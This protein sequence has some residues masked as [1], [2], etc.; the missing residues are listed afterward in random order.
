[1]LIY[2]F[3]FQVENERTY[4]V[5]LHYKKG[6]LIS[7]NVHYTGVVQSSNTTEEFKLSEVDKVDDINGIIS[8]HFNLIGNQGNHY[9][10]SM[11]WDVVNDPNFESPVIGK[12]ICH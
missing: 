4:H 9:I 1:M 7:E 10:G 3:G 11:T 2:F 6:I 8:W 5:V 12:A